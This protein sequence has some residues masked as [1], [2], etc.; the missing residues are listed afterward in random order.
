MSSRRKEIAL[1]TASILT[2][3]AVSG[4]TPPAMAGLI[5]NAS[6][7]RFCVNEQPISL[8]SYEI[9]GSS[10]VKLRHIGRATDF[11]VTYDA[12]ANSV[13]IELDKPY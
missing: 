13:R 10:Y 6:S 3:I 8:E 4:P 9:N 7:Q 12:T 1:V 2:G 5:A 11:S